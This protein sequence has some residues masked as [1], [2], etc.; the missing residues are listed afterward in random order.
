MSYIVIRMEKDVV[1]VDK[2]DNESN[3]ATFLTSMGITEFKNFHPSQSAGPVWVARWPGIQCMV[4]KGDVIE[5]KRRSEWD[6][7]EVP[8]SGGA[9]IA[10]AQMW[11]QVLECAT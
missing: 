7:G 4:I 6:F 5:P 11:R 10:E 2:F 8:K 1:R 3:L 9:C